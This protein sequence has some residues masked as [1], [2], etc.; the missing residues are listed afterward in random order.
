[1]KISVLYNQATL[2]KK[3]RHEDLVCEQE[4]LI[5]API[6]A[7]ILR[8][9]GH[10]VTLMLA[11][12]EL[13]N[14]L[15]QKRNEIDIVFNLAE[16]FGGENSNELFVPAML[17]A[18]DIPFTGP[19]FRTYVFAYDKWKT[20]TILGTFGIRHPSARLF[21]PGGEITSLEVTFPAIVKPVHE[22]ASLGITYDSVVTNSTDL[23]NRIKRVHKLYRQAALVEEFIAGRE[24]SVGCMGNGSHVHVFPPLEFVF[25]QKVPLER[26]IR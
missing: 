17:E 12:L 8:D 10:E 5:I 24:I 22:D 19:G 3:G 2:V 16:G 23:A 6:V 4:I 15:R 13:W 1:M 9:L 11:G 14:D 18:L 25:D 21:Y 26:R 20:A 7:D